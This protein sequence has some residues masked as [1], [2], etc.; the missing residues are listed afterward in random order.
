LNERPM[1]ISRRPS[2]TADSFPRRQR[3]RVVHI[4]P[5]SCSKVRSHRECPT[6]IR[7]R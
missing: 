6:S 4:A 2:W 7:M 5:L 3:L 1:R